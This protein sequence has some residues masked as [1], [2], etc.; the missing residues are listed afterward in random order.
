MKLTQE[1]GKILQCGECKQEKVI[2]A[3]FF[4][5]RKGWVKSCLE[6]YY[7]GFSKNIEETREII[8]KPEEFCER[9]NRPKKLWKKGESGKFEAYCFVCDQKEWETSLEHLHSDPL[10]IA[11]FFYQKGADAWP[12]IQRLV[13]FAYIQSL[14]QKKVLFEEKFEMWEGDN[15][16][17][18]SLYEKSTK[19]IYPLSPDTVLKDVKEPTEPFIKNLLTDVYE[20]SDYY[21]EEKKSLDLVISRYVRKSFMG[22]SD[23]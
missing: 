23:S 17:L 16:I 14:N 13:Y 12:T 9:H 11:K 18:I 5:E 21:E 19:G 10:K 6:C 1:I 2:R 15:P 3:M 7:S 22:V 4:H 8:L 20:K